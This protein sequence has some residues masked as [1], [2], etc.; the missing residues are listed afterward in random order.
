MGSIDAMKRGSDDRYF[1]SNASLKVAQG[2]SGAV[3]D[4]GSLHQFVPYLIQSVKHGF[5]DIGAKTLAQLNGQLYSGALRFE[6]RS[7]AAQREGGVHDLH[8]FERKLFS[9]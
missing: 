1:G 2:V 3:Q 7:A 9:A 5:Q 8:S 6:L 4:K